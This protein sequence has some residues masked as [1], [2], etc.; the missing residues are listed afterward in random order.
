MASLAA[1]RPM[2]MAPTWNAGQAARDIVAHRVT[3]INGTDEA[4]AQLLETEGAS[5]SGIRFFGYAAFNPAQGDIVERADLRGLKLVG[6][7]GTS[8]IQALFARQDECAPVADRML[9]GGLPVS[10]EARVRVRDPASGAVLAHGAQGELEF[11]AP[12]SR[13]VGYHGNPEA[14]RDA[15]TGDGYYRSGDLG[16]TLAEAREAA[17][18]ASAAA[19]GATLEDRVKAALRAISGGT[20]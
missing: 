16:Y 8:E 20:A 4:A 6:L 19:P 3:H 7:Y 2:V 12:S 9:G 17:R 1:G 15:F 14:T 13:M 10:P 18:A 5:F 11:L